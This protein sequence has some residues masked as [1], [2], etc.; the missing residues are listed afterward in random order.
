[1]SFE[2]LAAVPRVL[3]GIVG[4]N[5]AAFP[6]RWFCRMAPQEPAPARAWLASML[7]GIVTARTALD[8][9]AALTIS[10]WVLDAGKRE[11]ALRGDAAGLASR[12]ASRQRR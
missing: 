8:D 10:T 11:Q 6:A 7:A 9:P 4:H 12:T 1:V 5:P 3:A 2:D